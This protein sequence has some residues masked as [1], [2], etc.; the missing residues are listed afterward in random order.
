[1]RFAQRRVCDAAQRCRLFWLF[2]IITLHRLHGYP[3][4]ETASQAETG[5]THP[6]ASCQVNRGGPSCGA[7]SR[8][9]LLAGGYL[10]DQRK[11][12]GRNACSF[13]TFRGIASLEKNPRVHACAQEW[14]NASAHSKT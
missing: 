7:P 12:I 14:G 11:R 2:V 3:R 13:V 9:S 6:L 5:R 1:M 8:A 10:A 4:S